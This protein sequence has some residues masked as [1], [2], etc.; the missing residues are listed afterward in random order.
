M[1]KCNRCSGQMIRNE[2]MHGKYWCCAQCGYNI[3]ITTEIA[4]PTVSITGREFAE[5]VLLI[6]N[7]KF[8]G[9]TTL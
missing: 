4:Y 9:G 1:E 7:S 2:D 3:N 8:V 6:K 5:A